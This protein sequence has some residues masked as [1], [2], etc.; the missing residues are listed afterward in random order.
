MQH[1]VIFHD[2]NR[3]FSNSMFLYCFA[4]KELEKVQECMNGKIFWSLFSKLSCTSITLAAKYFYTHASIF[5]YISIK[6]IHI[7]TE[8]FAY[9]VHFMLTLSWLNDASCLYGYYLQRTNI[10][11]KI[12]FMIV[13]PFRLQIW[14]EWRWQ[15]FLKVNPVNFLF[16]S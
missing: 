3:S 13:F 2:L 7:W 9:R 4:S 15:I 11:N 12:K 16:L 14:N 5:Y 6:Q 8:K 1:I 10:W